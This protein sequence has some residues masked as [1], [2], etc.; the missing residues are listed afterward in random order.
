MRLLLDS[1]VA[2]W[3]LDAG[4]E[5]GPEC[6][7][8]IESADEVRFSAV[9]PLELGIKRSLG[10]LS[11][12]DGLVAALE[13]SGFAALPIS[14]AHAEHAPELPPHHRDPF[15]RML[16][17]QAQLEALALVSADATLT[18]YDVELI[19]PRR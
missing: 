17:A 16:V 15:D 10:K 18:P 5:L 14:A 2:L 3:W 13:A 12:P 9:T 4:D 8:L 1:H 6:V 19:D 11:Y 7:T